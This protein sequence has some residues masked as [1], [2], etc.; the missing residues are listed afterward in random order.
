MKFFSKAWFKSLVPATVIS[1][2]R[3]CGIF[4]FNPKVV[5][6]QDPC[7]QVMPQTSS[8]ES[9]SPSSLVQ[10]GAGS[11]NNVIK[12]FTEEEETHFATCCNESYDLPPYP[13]YLQ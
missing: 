5:L 13:R 7:E 4:P 1:G 2:F 11:S 8:V 6:D 9:T 12:V 10:R 3:S